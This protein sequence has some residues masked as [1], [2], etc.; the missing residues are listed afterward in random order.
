MCNGT[1]LARRWVQD[2]RDS[3][4]PSLDRNDARCCDPSRDDAIRGL[5]WPLT[6]AY[7]VHHSINSHSHVAKASVH[8]ESALW[9]PDLSAIA[10]TSPSHGGERAI[11]DGNGIAVD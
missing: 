5:S 1:R 4:L 7:L 9:C 3:A 2:S 11:A 6:N 10:G 8:P